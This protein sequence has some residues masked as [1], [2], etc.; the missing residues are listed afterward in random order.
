MKKI[1]SISLLTILFSS[2]SFALEKQSSEWLAY[3]AL[4]EEFKE[5]IRNTEPI[6]RK[7]LMEELRVGLN[8][9]I[10]DASHP[11]YSAK[12]RAE[13]EKLIEEYIQKINSF[14]KTQDFYKSPEHEKAK[15]LADQL[16][17]LL[18]SMPNDSLNESYRANIENL[19]TDMNA[20]RGDVVYF[21]DEVALKELP[22]KM[23]EAENHLKNFTKTSGAWD[24]SKHKK[25]PN[26]PGKP[27]E[28]HLE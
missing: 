5:L 26:T 9:A 25:E 1:A 8:S 2:V 22:S 15:Q 24:R 23:T 11:E 4:S 12:D 14:K 20:L 21:G 28:V 10:F 18:K 6:A 7:N 16:S 19:R 13:A 17:D 3:K 27:V